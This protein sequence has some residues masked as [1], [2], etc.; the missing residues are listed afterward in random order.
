MAS[1]SPLTEMTAPYI[2]IYI[3]IYIKKKKWISTPCVDL[4]KAFDSAHPEDPWKKTAKSRERHPLYSLLPCF[5]NC[6]ERLALHKQYHNYWFQIPSSF[7][8]TPTF[9]PHPCCIPFSMRVCVCVHVVWVLCVK[10]VLC[11]YIIF[12]VLCVHFVSWAWSCKAWYA[13]PC[14]WDTALCNRSPL[15]SLLPLY[16]DSGLVSHAVSLQVVQLHP[17]WCHH[18]RIDEN[19]RFFY[20]YCWLIA[21]S[22]AQGHLRAFH[23]FKFCT[24]VEYNTK[25][26][27]YTNVKHII[28]KVG[29]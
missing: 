29:R 12:D 19:Q 8:C 9:F 20:I 28:R 26:A 10:N 16:Y 3:R 22:T 21:Q 4:T 23:K 13:R 11:W 2:Y 17:G 24:Q 6:I 1:D 15:L 27:H 5:Q 7:F 14:Q 25:H 18:L